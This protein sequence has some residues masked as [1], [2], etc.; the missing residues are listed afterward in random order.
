MLWEALLNGVKKRC[1]SINIE[2][3]EKEQGHRED[4]RQR[5]EKR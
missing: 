2:S 3:L 5:K 4:N 1:V